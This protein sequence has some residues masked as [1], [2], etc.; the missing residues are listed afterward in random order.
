MILEILKNIVIEAGNSALSDF[1]K[2]NAEFKT[3]NSPVTKADY[4]VQKFLKTRLSAIFPRY[5]FLAEEDCEPPDVFT[6]NDYIWVI[7]PIDGTDAFREGIPI[8]GVSVGLVH[9]FQPVMGIFYM[10]CT[11]MVFY[12]DCDGKNAFENGRLID[13]KDIQRSTNIFAPSDLSKF[14]KVNYNLKI[15][16][17]GSTA[18]HICFLARGAGCGAIINGHPWDIAAAMAILKASG[19][20]IFSLSGTPF[21]FSSILS[22]NTQSEFLVASPDGKMPSFIDHFKLK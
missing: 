12:C 11:N 5:K 2:F 7:D 9:K 14:F 4:N 8:W 22:T 16:S 20:N 13:T 17:L 6:E 15:R 3:D 18:A 1:G 21:E 19:G 10:P